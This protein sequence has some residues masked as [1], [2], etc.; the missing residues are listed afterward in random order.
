LLAPRPISC[1][2]DIVDLVERIVTVSLDTVRIV[3]ALPADYTVP[4]AAIQP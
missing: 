1:H 4:A 3:A 2:S